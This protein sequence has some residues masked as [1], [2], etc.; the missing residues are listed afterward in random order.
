MGSC[1]RLGQLQ[2]RQHHAGKA[3]EKGSWKPFSSTSL[4][5]RGNQT[6]ATPIRASSGNRIL[7]CKEPE[8]LAGIHGLEA[9]YNQHQRSSRLAEQTIFIRS[10]CETAKVPEAW[11]GCDSLANCRQENLQDHGKGHA[12]RFHRKTA[13]TM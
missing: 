3:V 11:M 8:H 10:S 12:V 7:S 4:L 9:C 6:C 2:L 5:R 13:S 1:V